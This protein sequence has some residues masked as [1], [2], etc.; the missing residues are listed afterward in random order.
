MGGT[1]NVTSEPNKGSEFTIEIPDVLLMR[2]IR[3]SQPKITFQQSQAIGLA[4]I[5]Y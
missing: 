5:K 2:N 3:Q 4:Q 1:L